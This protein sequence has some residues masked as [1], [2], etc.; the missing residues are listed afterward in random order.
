METDQ[1]ARTR[2]QVLAENRETVQ[3]NLILR[4]AQQDMSSS[5]FSFLGYGPQAFLL[6]EVVP[7]TF[8]WGWL[9]LLVTA[10]MSGVLICRTLRR[11]FD[12][13]AKRK[14]WLAAF[15]LNLLINGGVWGSAILLPGV[16]QAPGS[17]PLQLVFI[18]VV[19]ISSTQ[20][21][22]MRASALAAYTFGMLAPTMALGLMGAIPYSFGLAGLGLS[23]M[24]QIYG[25]T[26]RKLVLESIAAELI[27]RKEKEAAE[28]ANRA[29]SVFLSNMSHELRTP[30]NSILGYTQLLSRQ[31]NLTRSQQRQLNVMRASG[32][33]LLTLI[34]DILDLS[35]IEA[36]KMEIS[37]APFSPVD[38][39]EQVVDIMRPRATQKG[40]VLSLGYDSALPALLLGDEKRVRQILLNLLVNAIKFTALGSVTLRASYSPDTESLCCEVVDTGIGIPEA[41]LEEIF[42]PF[43]QLASDLQGREG[44]GLGLTIC[45]RLAAMMDGTV[46]ASS[47]PEVGSCFRFVGVLQTAS[48][49]TPETAANA[50][51]IRGYHGNV[52][53]VLVVDDNP[54][55]ASLL[56]D[57]LEPLGF[58]TQTAGD[59]HHAMELLLA[60]PPD[61]VLL[62]LVM[63]GRDGMEIAHE[64]RRHPELEAVRIVGIS[65]T[66]TDSQRKQA[67]ME[68]CDAF[69]PKP[70][71][72]DALLDVIGRLLALTWET[73]E[74]VDS[75]REATRRVA[76]TAEML[77][78]V[79]AELRQRLGDATLSLDASQ[80]MALIPSLRS[81]DAVLAEVLTQHVR[82]H[83][84]QSILNAVG[85]ERA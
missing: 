20:V 55:N 9:A 43:T 71:Q 70:V 26:N 31:D 53:R 65:A 59:G 16:A 40:L 39:L 38:L 51:R 29:K 8:L 46:S 27:I 11:S 15:T 41:R 10:E 13:P 34:D 36:Q 1:L 76:L 32:Q 17:W 21:L 37:P 30:L 22:A 47:Q 12:D 62:D 68:A 66:L 3:Q 58:R 82:R 28:A 7:G 74:G 79:P 60:S 57:T 25:W 64:L 2:A 61:L 14:F 19:A 80:I 45:R 75:N 42:Q 73:D 48:A 56:Q 49:R 67:F 52:K 69:L 4:L 84:F 54:V 77:G 24:C 33:H 63:P 50:Q 85:D 5:L 83:D 18:G 81:I 35:K 6:S 72:I 78:E 23:V 44:V